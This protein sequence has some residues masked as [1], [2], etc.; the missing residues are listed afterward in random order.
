MKYVVISGA[1]VI[2]FQTVS[3]APSFA[4]VCVPY[5]N[6]WVP[7]QYVCK[8]SAR[9]NDM[10]TFDDF[11][12]GGCTRTAGYFKQIPKECPPPPTGRWVNAT[13]TTKQVTVRSGGRDGGEYT[14]TVSV[15]TSQ[16]ETCA[17]AGL[18]PAKLEGQYIC[19]SGERRPVIG[20]GYQNINYRFGTW[21]GDRVAGHAT[22]S[23]NTA[24]MCYANGQKRDS[25]GTDR[26][27]AWYCD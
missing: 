20:E 17:S 24:L 22:V 12:N 1:I 21:G 14:Q 4:Q 8:N 19:A 27:V 13:F 5:E 10:K 3:A 7:E 23:T 2:A 25:D 18:K 16:A 9:N 6:V 15:A 26:L 11:T